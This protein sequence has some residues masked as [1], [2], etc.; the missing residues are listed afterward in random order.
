MDKLNTAN[1]WS[2]LNLRGV[3]GFKEAVFQI[4]NDPKFIENAN[5]CVVYI[6]KYIYIV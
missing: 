4:L 5:C 2:Y 1:R 3:Q 6:V